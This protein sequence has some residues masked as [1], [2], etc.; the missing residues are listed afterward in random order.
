MG[1]Y[2]KMYENF[3]RYDFGITN[4]TDVNTLRDVYEMIV[5]NYEDFDVDDANTVRINNRGLKI[6]TKGL[7]IPGYKRQYLSMEFIHGTYYHIYNLGDY[8][9]AIVY[10][11]SDVRQIQIIDGLDSTIE[12]F[13]QMMIK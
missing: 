7:S 12:A 3:D 6:A 10:G 11:N 4:E 9:Y 1:R 13:K 2:I 5:D 8:C